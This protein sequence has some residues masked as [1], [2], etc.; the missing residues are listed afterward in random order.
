MISW[1]SIDARM[2][3]FVTDILGGIHLAAA[4]KSKCVVHV[5][6]IAEM[7]AGDFGRKDYMCP[8]KENFQKAD[9]NDKYI[10]T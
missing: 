9:A 5:I 6:M 4:S 8:L 2:I 10:T 7:C 1:H 3:F